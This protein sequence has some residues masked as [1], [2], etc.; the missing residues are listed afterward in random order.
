MAA[1]PHAIIPPVSSLTFHKIGENVTRRIAGE[2]LVVPVRATAAQLDSI[3]VLNEPGATI[4]TLLD[5]PRRAG[6]LAQAV[7]EDFDVT[8]ESAHTDVLRFLE[9][10]EAAGLVEGQPAE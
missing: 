8:V 7:T 2:T 3:F 10:L 6:E 9:R 4:W 1:R 5:I